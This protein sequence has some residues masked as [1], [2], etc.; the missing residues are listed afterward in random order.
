M[1]DCQQINLSFTDKPI[2]TN[3]NIHIKEGESACISGA[4]GM[5]KT[6][7]LKMLQGY[8][9]PNSG[10]LKVNGWECTPENIKKIRDTITWIP[11]NV[12]LQVN[13]GLELLK[14]MEVEPSKPT[15]ENYLVKLGLDSE[16]I[17]KD[18][19][20]IS[21]GQ[22]QRI[23]IAICLCL[24]KNVLLIDEPTSSLDEEAIKRLVSIIKNLK[25]KT[26]VSASHNQSWLQSVDQIITL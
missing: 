9:M 16:I 19:S 6:T 5:G 4:S 15:V 13:S 10:I 18:F 14:L 2:F 22:K 17:C 3:L 1:I 23:I 21:G 25:G 24:N 12:N 8:V 7:F 26:I 11:Q 20:K